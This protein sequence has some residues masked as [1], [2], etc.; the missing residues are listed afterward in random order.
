[1]RRCVVLA[2][3]ADT[4]DALR[5]W[6]SLAPLQFVDDRPLE[7]I[8]SLGEIANEG[9]LHDAYWSL[10]A[11]IDTW[12]DSGNSLAA[13]SPL[14]ILVDHVRPHDLSVLRGG[15]GEESR[16]GR[17]HALIAMLILSFPEVCWVFGALSWVKNKDPKVEAAFE[18]GCGFR[19]LFSIPISPVF[20]PFGLRNW[21]RKMT[22]EQLKDQQLPLRI[23]AAAIIEDDEQ[24]SFFHAYTAYRFGLQASIFDCWENLESEFKGDDEKGHGYWLLLEDMSLKY[25]GRPSGGRFTDLAE[26]GSTLKALDSRIKDREDSE[27]RVIVTSGQ[28]PSGDKTLTLNRAYLRQKAKGRARVVFKPASGIFDL[29][30]KAGLM[31]GCVVSRGLPDMHRG[32]YLE[33][34]PAPQTSPT[35]HGT[36]GRVALVAERLVLRASNLLKNSG[37]MPAHALGAVLATDALELTDGRATTLASEGLSL[38]QRFE[39]LIECDFS[40]IEYHI[41]VAPRI[42][43]I[44]AYARWIGSNYG[45]S[46]QEAAQQ[47]VQMHIL[48]QLVRILREHN[49]FDEEQICMRHVRHLHHSLWMRQ[50]KASGG[51]LMWPILRYLELLLSSFGNFLL[52]LAGWILVLTLLFAVSTGNSSGSVFACAL[53]DSVSTFFSVGPPAHI[54]LPFCDPKPDAAW[55]YAAVTSLGIIA[56]A[57]HLGVFISY[58]YSLL[59]R[60]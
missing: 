5:R 9:S 41:T 20:D 37:H 28:S 27:H 3:H 15:P 11:L 45:S 43:E 31:Q 48:N 36:D 1:M 55:R 18:A 30:R 14:T 60:R 7:W 29:W 38:K 24:F 25:P 23:K 34:E 59:S 26:R 4:A 47:N 57:F 16:E 46:Q 8:V 54:G 6:K 13:A 49:Q 44:A 42:R 21:V 56:G 52:A 50:H 2:Q 39:V 32:S 33:V 35:S 17:W 22:N 19:S 58:L 53:Q 40:G 51:Q 12:T 10:V